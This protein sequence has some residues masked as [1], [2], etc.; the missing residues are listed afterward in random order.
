MPWQSSIQRTAYTFANT[1]CRPTHR[2]AL[3]ALLRQFRLLRSR[4]QASRLVALGLRPSDIDPN[5]SANDSDLSITVQAERIEYYVSDS[6]IIA[7]IRNAH[8]YVHGFVRLVPVS[9]ASMLAMSVRLR[10]PGLRTATA[11]SSRNFSDSAS[12]LGISD[13][14]PSSSTSPSAALR[15]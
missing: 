8:D 9:G 15:G 7:D 3:T 11:V 10:T 4:L 12:S 2:L 13:I 5:I 1:I 14:S 6:R